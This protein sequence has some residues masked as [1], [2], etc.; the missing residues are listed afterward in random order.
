MISC[1]VH[2]VAPT[3]GRSSGWSLPQL[4]PSKILMSGTVGLYER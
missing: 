1:V 3:G 2:V 4:I